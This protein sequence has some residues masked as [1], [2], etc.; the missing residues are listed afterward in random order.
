MIRHP[1][2]TKSHEIAEAV[3][4][5]IQPSQWI[6]TQY[7]KNKIKVLV[8]M[9]QLVAIALVASVVAY[10]QI[11]SPLYQVEATDLIINSTDGSRVQMKTVVVIDPKDRSRGLMY[12]RRLPTNMSM[13][14]L[15]TNERVM[16][17]WMKNTYVALDMWFVSSSGRIVHIEK[18]TVPLSEK[19]ISSRVPAKAVVEVNAGLS[20]RLGISIGATVQH[21]ALDN[22]D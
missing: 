11:D 16:S 21:A 6:M 4:R 12:V 3:M 14:F 8:F 9:R 1:G 15:N 20:D 7:S 13:L 10:A 22:V 19:S 2:N 5:K 18:N 17:M